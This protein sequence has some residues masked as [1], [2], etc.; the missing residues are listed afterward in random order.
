MAYFAIQTD[1]EA[2]W[3]D[4]ADSFTALANKTLPVPKILGPIT[5]AANSLLMAL[6]NIVKKD[7]Q[8]RIETGK[9]TP[10]GGGWKAWDARYARTR[11]PGDSLL[12]QADSKS[13]AG[14]LIN[15]INS[16]LVSSSEVGT[17]TDIIYG[18]RQNTMREF[19]GITQVTEELLEE[20]I[21]DSFS[22]VFEEVFA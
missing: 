4:L 22:Q 8:D 2:V 21:V 11:G 14:S 9:K 13:R 10:D 19:I 5:S 7:I 18:E 20:V 17:G 3:S 15:S 6:G 1:A 16:L 12:L